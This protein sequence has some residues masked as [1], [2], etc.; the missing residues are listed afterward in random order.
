[1]AKRLVKSCFPPEVPVPQ[2]Q[3]LDARNIIKHR[4]YQVACEE[5]SKYPCE[6]WKEVYEVQMNVSFKPK[7][8]SDEEAW[9]AALAWAEAKAQEREA[10]ATKEESQTNTDESYDSDDSEF[11][12]SVQPVS[13]VICLFGPDTDE[14]D[15]E[16]EETFVRPLPN[17]VAWERGERLPSSWAA[18]V[19]A[20]NLERRAKNRYAV[21][22]ADVMIGVRTKAA[23]ARVVEEKRAARIIQAAARGRE[24]RAWNPFV[25]APTV[26]HIDTDESYDSEDFAEEVPA[27]P[28]K[29]KLPAGAAAGGP[30]AAM[31]GLM[32]VGD[33]VRAN[34]YSLNDAAAAA[35]M[36]RDDAQADAY[37]CVAAKK[38]LEALDKLFPSAA[39]KYTAATIIQAAARG[40]C[41]RV[42][43]RGTR[44]LFLERRILLLDR[45]I[46]RIDI[47]NAEINIY[48]AATIIQAAARGRAV[49]AWKSQFIDKLAIELV[50]IHRMR[51]L[52]RDSADWSW[53]FESLMLENAASPKCAMAWIKLAEQR[54]SWSHNF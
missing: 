20:E 6:R 21:W 27:P 45:R 37:E 19:D 24:V 10:L 38:A 13:R 8:I 17:I 29:P 16:D 7:H 34:V 5:A 35:A 49:R 54:R 53:W 2:L 11:G 25:S 15:F 23:A 22:V 26:S 9:E 4:S 28:Q 42:W 40:M 46:L 36:W 1:M 12:V 3:P 33:V 44:R 32:R 30:L 18:W 39:R 41:C 51:Y 43:L 50:H 31:A 47:H 14:D 48:L 52:K